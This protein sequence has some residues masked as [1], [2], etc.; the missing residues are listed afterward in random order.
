MCHHPVQ[1]DL[2]GA[3]RLELLEAVA[4]T[5]GR[6]VTSQPDLRWGI[7]FLDASGECLH[8]VYLDGAGTRAVM[9]GATAKVNHRLVHWLERNFG[10]Q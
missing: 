7:H 9:D 3:L 1:K 6:E 4:G 10:R 2:D 5:K 8:K